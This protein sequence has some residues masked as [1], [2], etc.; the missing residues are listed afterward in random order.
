[1]ANEHLF[2]PVM[3]PYVT[4]DEHGRQVTA[5][6]LEM[7]HRS[8]L[9]KALRSHFP[10]LR[11]EP[12][13]IEDLVQTTYMKAW[14]HRDQYNHK[15]KFSTWL[16]RIAINATIDHMRKED[17]RRAIFDE[18]VSED[19]LMGG[20][21][22]LAEDNEG[23]HGEIGTASWE[24]TIE[25][26]DGDPLAWLEAEEALAAANEIVS[27][28]SDTLRETFIMREVQDMPYD[29]IAATLG[30][31]VGTVRSR[32]NEARRLIREEVSRRGDTEALVS[33]YLGN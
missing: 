3:T 19:D 13:T 29:D 30:I 9:T 7:P 15:A 26:P 8:L 16:Y 27:T 4:H 22:D 33:N 21:A 25:D 23:V 28:L 1:M 31:P 14:E 2:E 12:D 6:R 20:L 5:E 11:E 32:L 17:Q 18:L 10:Q 24:D